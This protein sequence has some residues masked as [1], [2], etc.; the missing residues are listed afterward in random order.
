MEV[1]LKMGEARYTLVVVAQVKSEQLM[2]VGLGDFVGWWL[3]YL[4]VTI[5]MVRIVK[6][7]MWI[8][9]ISLCRTR[10]TIEVESSQNDDKV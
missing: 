3:Y 10:P 4:I 2:D 9:M 1:F 8:F 7:L 5:G 6:G